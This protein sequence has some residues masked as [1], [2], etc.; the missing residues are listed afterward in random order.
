M[1]PV[2]LIGRRQFLRVASV[3]G[4]GLTIGFYVGPLRLRRDGLEV[5]SDSFT[6]NA[7]LRIDKEGAITITIS[8][9]EMGQ[10]VSTALPMILAEELEADWTRVRFELADF[11]K[12]Y[13]NMGTGGSQSVRSM[14]K[15]L[16]EAGAAARELLISAAAKRWNVPREECR[17]EMGVILHSSGRKVTFGEVADDAAALPLPQNIPLKDPKEFRTLGKRTPRLDAPEKV[18]G[19]AKFGIDVRV[20]GML[21]AVVARCPVFGGKVKSHNAAKAKASPGVRHVVEI[22]QG[23][24]VVADSTWNAM[25]GRNALEVDWDE[26]TNAGLNSAAIHAMLEEFSDK[27]GAVAE[28]NGDVGLMQKAAK[29][30]DATYEVPFLAHATMEPMNATADVRN[31]KCEIWA[32]TQSPEWARGATAEALGGSPDD[33][34]LH[35][36]FLGGGFGRRFDPDFVVEAVNVSKAVN[37]PVKVVWTREDDIQHDWYRPTSLHRLEAGLSENGD[38]L[39]LKHK[40][41][42][43]SINGQR[44]PERIKGGLDRSAVEGAVKLEYDVPNSRVEYV[45]ANTAVPVGWWR[46]VYPTQNVFVV[47]S[48]IDELAYAAGKD[49][50]DFRRRLLRKDSRLK[51]VLETAARKAEWGSPLPKGIYRGIAC[52]PPAFFGSFV[53]H[54]AEVSVDRARVK[55]HRIVSAV[56]CGICINP[57]TVEAQIEGSVAFA[58]GAL[59]SGEITIENGR[60]IQGNFD[61]YPILMIDQMP[62]VEVYIVPSG[63]PV[64][65]MGEPGVPPLAPA[66]A[67]AVFAATGKRIRRLPLR[68]A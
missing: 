28:E 34:T 27:E 29:R 41:T 19:S 26:G 8:K 50:Y 18:D 58:L 12:K 48:F 56:D 68:L 32:P 51:R 31:D 14:W 43:P 21:Y 53:A 9:S 67:N 40:I 49:P 46:S 13:G 42:A 2:S 37:A 55:V 60:V 24:A 65:G 36:T 11:D 23:I 7:W 54:V 52:A 25:Q 10:G 45:M 33:V 3:A 64:G 35:V 16:R 38:L 4:A 59:L 22:P 15:P 66:I 5:G 30:V 6:P 1:K 61:D 63:E 39:A 62:K 47:E 44:W 17:A 57:L 20:P